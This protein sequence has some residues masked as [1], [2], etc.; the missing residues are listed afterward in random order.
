MKILPNGIAV[1]DGDSHISAWVEESGRLDHDQN[2]LPL[3]LEH[4]KAGDWVVD[5][6]AFI[7]DHTTAYKGKVGDLGMVFAFEPNK[8][9]FECLVHNCPSVDCLDM[10]LSD[11]D[12]VGLL[13]KNRNAGASIV[14]LLG[15]HIQLIDLD[16]LDLPRLDFLK[17]DVEGFET[18]ALRG[19]EQ[20]ILKCRPKMWIEVNRG[21]LER[22]G[23]SVRELMEV[24]L[25]MGYKIEPYPEE[26]GEQYDVLCI[27]L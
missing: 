13:E 20:T 10:G 6:G 27:P 3:I 21:C 23:S 15:E 12:S 1:I 2:A 19:A 5:G 16:Y 25:S 26:G 8:E 14:G 24:I 4:I 9:A 7:G 17:L 18:K 11:R 22:Q